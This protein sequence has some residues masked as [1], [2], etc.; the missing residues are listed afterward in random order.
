MG[1]TIIYDGTDH[2]PHDI[3]DLIHTLGYVRVVRCK[4]C[5]WFTGACTNFNGMI[6]PIREGY[7]SYGEEQDHEKHIHD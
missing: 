2:V 6:E 5:K 3:T 7:C 4:D 1:E